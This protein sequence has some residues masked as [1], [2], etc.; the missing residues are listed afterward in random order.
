MQRPAGVFDP[1]ARRAA[2]DGDSIMHRH[3]LGEALRLDAEQLRGTLRDLS[4]LA[5]GF[6]RAMSAAFRKS[7]LEGRRLK[8]VLRGL[9]LDL[10]NRALRAALAPVE[11]GISSLFGQLVGG[12]FGGIGA[13]NG[14]VVER[15]LVRPFARGGVVR[16]PS[17]FPLAG[18]AGPGARL[19]LMGEA[20]PEAI[21]PLARGPD[22]RLG[23]RAAGTPGAVTIH[24]HVTTP[25]AASFRRAEADIA[26]ML[27]R[28]VARGQRGL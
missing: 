2:A 8:D 23:V 24:F 3:D 6:G 15:G 5:D 11:R 28:A 25:D 17:V 13:A 10:S 19:G 9:A 12:L 26:A 21:M 22:G 14:A 4:G 20:G 18:A 16:A 1:G 27:A 7:A